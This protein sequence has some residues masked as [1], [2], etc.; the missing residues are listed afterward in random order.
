MVGRHISH[1]LRP[2]DT[3]AVELAAV[4]QHLQKERIIERRRYHALTARLPFPLDP[5]VAQ[6]GPAIARE[7]LSDAGLPARIGD[8]E[9]RFLHPQRVENLL[10]FESVK[11][12]SA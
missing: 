2:K 12:F 8:V 5:R 11:R 7:R 9:T 3:L 10:F 4:Q 1:C 6:G